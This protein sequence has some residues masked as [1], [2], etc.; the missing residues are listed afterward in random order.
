MASQIPGEA[1]VV[2]VLVIGAGPSGAV[3]THT[4]AA[5]GLSVVCLEQGD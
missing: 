5:A 3:V 1:D 2:D 4:A